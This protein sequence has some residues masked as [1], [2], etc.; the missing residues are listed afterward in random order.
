[1]IETTDWEDDGRGKYFYSTMIC[2]LYCKEDNEYFNCF[3]VQNQTRTG[4]YYTDWY[5]TYEDAELKFAQEKIIPEV[6]VPAHSVVE[7]V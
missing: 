6:I 4:S 3:V 1:L 7:L 2:Q 5:Y